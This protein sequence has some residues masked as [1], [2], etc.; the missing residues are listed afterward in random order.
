MKTRYWLCVLVIGVTGWLGCSD[1][2]EKLT[3]S[4]IAEYELKIPQGNHDYDTKIVD[5]YNRTGVYVLYK[6]SD[7]EIYY[8][9]D[10]NWGIVYADTTYSTGTMSLGGDYYVEDGVLYSLYGGEIGPLGEKLYQENGT[11]HRYTLDGDKIFYEGTALAW[12]GSYRVSEA[13]EAYAGKQFELLGELFLDLYTDEMLREAMLLKVL[14]GQKLEYRSG[15][16]FIQENY[17]VNFNNLIFNYGNQVIDDLTVSQKKTIKSELNLWFLSD[18]IIPLVSLDDFYAEADY[19][20][21]GGTTSSRPT[22][23]ASYGL[24]FVMRPSTSISLTDIQR[25]D[26]RSYL[27]M[28]INNPYETLAAEPVNGDYNERDYTG[29]LHEK[30][31]KNGKIRKRYD[32]LVNAFKRIGVDLQAIGNKTIEN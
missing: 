5:F 18:R 31:D 29:I 23:A 3:P 26:W 12:Q 32:I 17:R 2:D 8:N 15:T 7:A 4:D 13:D 22:E 20:W 27:T 21:A 19:Y 24:G 10:N 30:K 11:W 14:L 6:Y 9:G 1:D 28:I 16:R 25:Y